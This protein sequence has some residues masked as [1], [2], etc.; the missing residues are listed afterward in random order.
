MKGGMARWRRGAAGG[1]S[2]EQAEALAAAA[3]AC[4]GELVTTVAFYPIQLV[5]CRL[6]AAI[7]GST[8]AYAYS[9]LLHGIG[10]VFKEEGILGL[11]GGISPVMVQVMT[12]RRNK[13]LCLCNFRF[14]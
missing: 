9:G 8:D 7:R 5:K 10:C 13:I 2:G 3:G 4:A 6:Q 14:L 1:L 12:I 11:F